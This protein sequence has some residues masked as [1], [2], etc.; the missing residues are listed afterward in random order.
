M[1][2]NRNGDTTFENGEHE[3]ATGYHEEPHRWCYSNKHC[4][5]DGCKAEH[6]AW[7]K[8]YRG[9]NPDRYRWDLLQGEA[10]VAAQ[11]RLRER[12]RDEFDQLYEE[13]KAKRGLGPYG[14]IDR[15]RVPVTS[16]QEDGR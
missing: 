10:H 15:K 4:R 16:Q 1:G 2:D 14:Q 13:E 5:C 6:S 12:H 7:Q 9:E 11:G 3:C 8:Q